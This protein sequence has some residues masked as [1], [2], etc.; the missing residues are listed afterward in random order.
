MTGFY[1]SAL[2]K[3]GVMTNT[4][5]SSHMSHFDPVAPANMTRSS[6]FPMER[7]DAGL[8]PQL[9]HTFTLQRL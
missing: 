5:F 6:V 7:T 4:L 2:S 3:K 9:G 1:D 8:G